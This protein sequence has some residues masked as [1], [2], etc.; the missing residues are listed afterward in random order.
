MKRGNMEVQMNGVAQPAG[1][2]PALELSDVAL[3]VALWLL[4]GGAAGEIVFCSKTIEEGMGA[5]LSSCSSR[6]AHG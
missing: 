5:P 6:A 2:G 4:Y 1:D 3:R